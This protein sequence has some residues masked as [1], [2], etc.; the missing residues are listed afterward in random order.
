MAD[1]SPCRSSAAA[2]SARGRRPAPTNEHRHTI[3]R[4]NERLEE[5]KRAQ[6]GHAS[7][8]SRPRRVRVVFRWALG[9]HAIRFHREAVGRKLTFQDHLR[10]VLER[11]WDDPAV[12]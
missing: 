2:G 3:T 1:E 12:A 4:D 5:E 6:R 8:T 7:V 10:I 9:H 11:V